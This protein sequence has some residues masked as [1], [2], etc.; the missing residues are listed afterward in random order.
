MITD[1]YPTPGFFL[2]VIIAPISLNCLTQW[3]LNLSA[4]QNHLGSSRN[5]GACV[6][7]P[8]NGDVISFRCGLG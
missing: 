6:L 3:F 1:S 2:T 5:T 8:R 7:P 4:Q